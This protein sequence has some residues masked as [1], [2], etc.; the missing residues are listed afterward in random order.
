MK[1]EHMSDS[2]TYDEYKSGTKREAKKLISTH[3]DRLISANDIKENSPEWYLLM[4]L[5]TS[6]Q[7]DHS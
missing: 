1:T 7:E 6:V 4:G 5:K 2:Y 3:I